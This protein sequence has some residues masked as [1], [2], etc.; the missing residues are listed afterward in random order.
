MVTKIKMMIIERQMEWNRRK[1]IRQMLA[2]FE[3][4]MRKRR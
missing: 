4:T 3:K 1:Q 2:G